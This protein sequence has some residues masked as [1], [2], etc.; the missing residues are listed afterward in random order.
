[1]LR[2]DLRVSLQTMGKRRSHYP[3]PWLTLGIWLLFLFAG[4]MFAINVVLAA[5]G[6][7]F[8]GAGAFALATALFLFLAKKTRQEIRF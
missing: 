3:S 5:I 6:R 8:W 4:A 1:M 2:T 7:E